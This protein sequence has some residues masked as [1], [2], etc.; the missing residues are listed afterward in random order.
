MAIKQ[1]PICTTQLTGVVGKD[2]E[3]EYSSLDI[4]HHV[5]VSIDECLVNTQSV[6]HLSPCSSLIHL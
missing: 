6:Q 3:S 2:F 1:I 5:L 4:S